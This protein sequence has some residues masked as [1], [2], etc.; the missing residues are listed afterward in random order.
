MRSSPTSTDALMA[1]SKS[2]PGVVQK[3]VSK[4][5]CSQVTSPFSGAT[6]LPPLP[7]GAEGPSFQ[8]VSTRCRALAWFPAHV[9]GGGPEPRRPHWPE[10]RGKSHV[11]GLNGGHV[12]AGAERTPR[13]GGFFPACPRG[14]AH[15]RGRVR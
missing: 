10:P 13:S 9:K 5:V 4:L 2:P 11:H 15:A 12:R 8:A 14:V 1:G 6:P 7:G 3:A